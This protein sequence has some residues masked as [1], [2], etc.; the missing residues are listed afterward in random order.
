[1]KTLYN[2]IEGH[3]VIFKGSGGLVVKISA[4]QPRDHGIK[5]YSGHDH[6]STWLL[7]GSGLESD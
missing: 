1:M 5:P 4:S 3:I 6:V 7:S 2:N